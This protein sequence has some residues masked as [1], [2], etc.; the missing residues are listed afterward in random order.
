VFFGR[1]APSIPSLAFSALYPGAAFRQNVYRARYAKNDTACGI[2]TFPL[3]R[4]E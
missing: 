1:P 2:L 4:A 3:F